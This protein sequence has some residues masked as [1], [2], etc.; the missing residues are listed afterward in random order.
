M[1]IRY[2][3]RYALV[4]LKKKKVIINQFIID[5]TKSGYVVLFSMENTGFRCIM[6]DSIKVVF[7]HHSK[8]KEGYATIVHGLSRI[9]F[10]GQSIGAYL[11]I[12]DEGKQGGAPVI[13]R[14]IITDSEN[15]VY[16]F[17]TLDLHIKQMEI[18]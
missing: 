6:I 18:I 8:S 1:H 13:E 12:N 10:R 9:L 15:T 5:K 2:L 14:I 16:Q 3:L 7:N 11:E 4:G 17:Q